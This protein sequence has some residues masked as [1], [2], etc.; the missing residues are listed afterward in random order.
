MRRS[1]RKIVTMAT[2]FAM[3]A[4]LVS[5]PETAQAAKKTKP[6]LP[7]K[8][9]M[10]VSKTKTLKIKKVTKS[11]IKKTSWKVSDKKKVKL[12]KKKKNSVKVK[13]LRAGTVKVTAKVKMKNG[14]TY[15]L[16]SKVTI[17]KAGAP[18]E[19]P[20]ATFSATVQP[21]TTPQMTVQ[22]TVTPQAPIT[23]SATATVAPI[24]T[25]DPAQIMAKMEALP[26]GST[27]DEKTIAAPDLMTL[28]DGTK[29]TTK[30]QWTERRAEIKAI[31]QRYMYGMWR[32]GSEEEVTCVASEDE[33]E[34]T[35]KRGEETTSFSAAVTLPDGTAPEGDWP[36][37][38]SVGA[39]GN[40]FV[41]ESGYAIISFNTGDVASDNASRNGAFYDLYPY[42][43]SDWKEQTGSVMAWAWGASKILDALEAG[44]GATLNIST[45]NT[46]VTGVSR[47][48]KAAAAAGAF[49]HRFKVSMPVCSGYGGMTMGRYNSN[50]LTYNLL[51]DFENDPKKDDVADLAVWKST[52]G[53]EPINSLQGAGWFNE[54]YKQFSSYQN[55]PFDAHYIAALSAMED[56]YLFI[57]TG[58]NSDMWSSPPGF[59]WCYNE[60]KPAFELLGLED[61][62][63]IQMHLNLHGIETVD[64]CKLF[65]FTNHYFYNKDTNPAD[66]PSPWNELLADFTLED[67]KT[68]VFASEANQEAYMAGMPVDPNTL[69]PNPD[70]EVAVNVT[71]GDV[72]TSTIVKR[73]N[74]SDGLVSPLTGDAEGTGFNFQ[75]GPN[76]QYGESYVRFTLPEGMNISDYNS[77]SFTIQTDSNYY[78][79]KYALVA[80]P[81]ETGLPDKIEYDY[82]TGDI[83]NAIN[84][85]GGKELPNSTSNATQLTLDIDKDLAAPLDGIA[86]EL[87]L[88]IHMECLEGDAQYTIS[89]IV[90]N[91]ANG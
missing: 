31:L 87:T 34:I 60:A 55:L 23:P 28:F 52:G 2:V 58:I 4:S 72:E 78:G 26:E 3:G 81:K 8:V 15:K 85:S 13:A 47:Y 25:D 67:L 65:T 77:V 56:R 46:I 41:E 19:T 30:E 54:T 32:D 61:N 45:E 7:K 38:V 12:S 21:T 90:F 36:V 37:I 89:N 86:T 57:V 42:D 17:K 62:L 33:L 63:A 73:S 48:G 10:Q 43:S 80:N 5:V 44:A 83:S 64:L 84:L 40:D 14:K 35:I 59:W 49:E 74:T 39:F 9:T 68:C 75:Y 71:F 70:N 82:G 79:K 24:V 50:N 18:V 6:M 76:M 51:P 1:T 53:N 16:T 11:K 66:F 69:P 27:Y 91:S 29:I 88:Y 22:P 20:Q